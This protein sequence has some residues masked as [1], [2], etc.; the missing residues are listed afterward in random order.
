[1]SEVKKFT[2]AADKAAK[3]VSIKTAELAKVVAELAKI[4]ESIP[5][6]AEEIQNK[7]VELAGLEAQAKESFRKSDAELK[8]LILENEDKVL[9]DLMKKRNLANIQ[10]AQLTNIEQD[11]ETAQQD[12]TDAINKAVHAAVNAVKKDAEI[13]AVKDKSTHEIELATLRADKVALEAKV[14]HLESTI[15]NLNE[16]ITAEREARVEVAKVSQPIIQ[17]MTPTTSR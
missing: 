13:Q 1:M 12:H 3:S 14:Q 5:T 7:E 4:T 8:L 16:T 9:A 6:L 17:T 11:L 2:T 15:I 10:A